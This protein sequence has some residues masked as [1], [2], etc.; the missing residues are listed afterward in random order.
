MTEQLQT[1]KLIYEQPKGFF[2]LNRKDLLKNAL[3]IFVI[4]FVL[5]IVLWLTIA[6]IN[7]LP[8]VPL[9]AFYKSTLFAVGVTIFIIM[10]QPLKQKEYERMMRKISLDDSFGFDKLANTYVKA[11]KSGFVQREI[12]GSYKGLIFRVN[13][14]FPSSQYDPV[15]GYR[16]FLN[17]SKE[18]KDLTKY[19][20]IHAGS[21]N[22]SIIQNYGYQLIIPKNIALASGRFE[23][24]SILEEVYDKFN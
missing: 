11:D 23:L 8:Y 19:N 2:E 17:T 7:H 5:M 22:I 10:L 1:S 14:K 21:R 4:F 6:T 20:E 9:E 16:I 15:W 13:F 24:R 3:V 18:I 12:S